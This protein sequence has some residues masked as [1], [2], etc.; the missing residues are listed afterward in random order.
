MSIARCP[1]CHDEV[2]IPSYVSPDVLVECPWCRETYMLSEVSGSLPPMLRVVGPA[3]G[4]VDIAPSEGADDLRLAPAP[5]GRPVIVEERLATRRPVGRAKRAPRKK[6]IFAEGAKILA[7]GLVGLTIGQLI[8]WWMPGRWATSQRDPLGLA[9]HVSRW[10]PQIVPGHLRPAAVADDSLLRQA[11]QATASGVSKDGSISDSPSSS[12]GGRPGPS[13]SLSPPGTLK[14]AE[15]GPRADSRTSRSTPKAVGLPSSKTT[16]PGD[17]PHAG[18][19]NESPV[20]SA[21]QVP[22]DA[23]P[24]NPPAGQNSS[25]SPNAA[26]RASPPQSFSPEKPEP[27]QAHL[28]SS[29]RMPVPETTPD[30]LVALLAAAQLTWD[31][32]APENRSSDALPLLLTLARDT[33]FLDMSHPDA[34]DAYGAVEKWIATIAPGVEQCRR[35]ADWAEQAEG[36]RQQWPGR[37]VVGSVVAQRSSASFTEVIVKNEL[38]G[39][40]TPV[41]LRGS[42]KTLPPGKPVMVLGAMCTDIN[43][44]LPEYDGQGKPVLL[45]G[46]IWK[47]EPMDQ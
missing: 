3:P 12:S 47:P 7:G 19:T 30:E 34:M 23:E 9:R 14:T 1:R 15:A 11:Q 8:L 33:A 17:Q 45:G 39:L 35:L 43:R 13:A 38:T 10:I 6:N 22:S 18:E 46:L 31:Q 42:L 16:L 28:A 24:S 37:I 5:P 21:R 32:T 2:T 40:D 4:L 27:D 44:V 36:S 20:E 41:V 26:P 25:L 29:D